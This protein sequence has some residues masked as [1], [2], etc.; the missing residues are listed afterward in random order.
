MRQDGDVPVIEVDELSKTFKVPVR[1]QGLRASVRSLVHR[2]TREVTAVDAV[3][4]TIEPGEVV[5]FSARTA[6][7]RPRR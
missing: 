2:E 7:A 5:G 3:S 6:P 4:F 1:E